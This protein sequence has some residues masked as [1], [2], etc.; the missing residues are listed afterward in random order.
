MTASLVVLDR[1]E[2]GHLRGLVITEAQRLQDAPFPVDQVEIADDAKARID[3]LRT[4]TRS[5][6]RL[7]E[8][9]ANRKGIRALQGM[10]GMLEAA[11][12][13]W[14][15]RLVGGFRDRAEWYSTSA[16]IGNACLFLTVLQA[17]LH[18]LKQLD[19]RGVEQEGLAAASPW[20][21]ICERCLVL[22]VRRACGVC[23]LQGRA[24]Y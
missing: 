4:F 9:M 15:D 20:P 13:D 16:P 24:P 21:A 3:K 1:P 17:I 7:V 14:N 12:K 8:G 23:S 2:D 22:F 11:Q 19:Q 5:I 18:E 10:S 6:A